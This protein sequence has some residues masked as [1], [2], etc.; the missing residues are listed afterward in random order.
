MKILF[1]G[2]GSGGHFYPIIAVAEKLNT[3]LEAEKIA[4]VDF[5]Y[6][7][8]EPYNE[9]LL[10]DNKI[11]FK[12]VTAGKMRAYASIQN[13]FDFF[14]TGWGVVKA[15]FQLFALYPDVVFGKGGY[16]SFPVLVAARLFRIPV[17]LHE[18]DSVPG[19]VNAWAGQ[20]AQKVAISYAE[21][22]QFFPAGRTALTGNPIREEII[23]P[24]G[25]DAFKELGLDPNIP[26]L[27]VLGG[28]QGARNINSQLETLATR[29]VGEYQVIHQTGE[30]NVEE[31]RTTV[32][33][34]LAG[35]PNASRYHIYGYM[36]SE[37]MKLCAEAATVVVS[38]AGSAI[39]EIAAWGIPAILI[40]IANHVGD[41]QRK[42]AFAYARAGG[43][44][45]IEEANLAP[46]LLFSEVDNL[47]KDSEKRARMKEAA[48][49]FS[50][51][52]AAE[53]IAEQIVAVLL[54]HQ[55]VK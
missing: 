13:F 15:I 33:G 21:A 46:N 42:N 53:R 40:P 37:T 43:A 11:K 47:M 45:V 55:G 41:H 36:D 31:V 5:Y 39:F 44:V 48:K 22:A 14:K 25:K 8:T 23:R 50:R 7:S 10:Y 6:M 30:A 35:H 29:L 34:L 4:N 32:S 51:T 52:D 26:V 28:S 49:V 9:R 27:L 16:P 18:S 54:R 24:T 2:G 1:T 20:F 12:Q 38:R 17:I 19:R 3:M